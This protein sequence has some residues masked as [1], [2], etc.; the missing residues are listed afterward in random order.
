M[1]PA[2]VIRKGGY[3][4]VEW[5]EGSLLADEKGFKLY[6]LNEWF[7]HEPACRLFIGSSLKKTEV[8]IAFSD[9]RKTEVVDS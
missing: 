8:S 1:T 7:Y 5:Y 3:K 4:L 6:N 2:A 9:R